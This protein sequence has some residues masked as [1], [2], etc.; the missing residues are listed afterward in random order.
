[1]DPGLSGA[2]EC[3]II[4]SNILLALLDWQFTLYLKIRYG[5]NVLE[6]SKREIMRILII[7]H[8]T[9]V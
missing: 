4:F 6:L 8:Q 2:S 1:M 5:S 9:G 7:E 3:L